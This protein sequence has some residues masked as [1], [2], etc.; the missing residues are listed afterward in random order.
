MQ[1]PF[2]EQRQLTYGVYFAQPLDRQ[3]TEIFFSALQMVA[4]VGTRYCQIKH[5]VNNNEHL[6]FVLEITTRDAVK[7]YGNQNQQLQYFTN[8]LDG[9]AYSIFLA[10]RPDSPIIVRVLWDS[11]TTFS[12][13]ASGTVK[14]RPDAFARLVSLL[15]HEIYGNVV[16][17]GRQRSVYLSPQ[18]RNSSALRQK[19][20]IKSEVVAF[21]AGV[22]FLQT[23][24]QQFG[25][26]V[27]QKLQADFIDA[28]QREATTL[29]YYLNVVARNNCQGMAKALV[30]NFPQLAVRR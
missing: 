14:E 24:L 16:N 13:E 20:W 6:D 8:H 30:V 10:D 23:L 3:L 19:E 7:A 17:F 2:L 29:E 4:A 9:D 26:H 12:E 22:D 28:L 11:A 18:F 25:P 1:G 15:G 21:H 27:S 5:R